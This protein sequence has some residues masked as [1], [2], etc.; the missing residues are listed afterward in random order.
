M[1]NSDLFKNGYLFKNLRDDELSKI[2]DIAILRRFESGDTI[3]RE[4]NEANAIYIVVSGR[5]ALSQ[6]VHDSDIEFT[7]INPGSHFGEMAFI[8]GALRSATATCT[9]RS[10]LFEVRYDTLNSVL[11]ADLHIAT[12]L[13]CAFS[14]FLVGRLRNTT[15]D[16]TFAKELNTREAT[17]F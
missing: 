17:D 8:D 13:Y 3:F 6:S 2:I 9:Q 5:V 1:K 4:N 11:A 14:H 16:L 12:K 10:E 15:H 7:Q